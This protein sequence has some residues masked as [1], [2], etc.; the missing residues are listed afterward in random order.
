MAGLPFLKGSEMRIKRREEIPITPAIEGALEDIKK[1]LRPGGI[2]RVP[3]AKFMMRKP[4]KGDTPETSHKRAIKEF[5]RWNNCFVYHNLNAGIGVFRGVPDLTAITPEGV[6]LQ[7]EVKAPG[8]RQS[9][10]QRGFEDEWVRRQGVYLCGDIDTVMDWFRAKGIRTVVRW[11]K[12][13]DP[14]KFGEAVK[15]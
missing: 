4:R 14:K 7:I 9:P 10:Q 1:R 5:L 11:S 8:G 12:H 6:A 13:G 15:K 3:S 2:I